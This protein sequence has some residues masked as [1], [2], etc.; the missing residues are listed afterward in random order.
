MKTTRLTLVVSLCLAACGGTDTPD[1]GALGDAAFDATTTTTDGAAR[2][3][4]PDGAATD[5][6]ARDGGEATSDGALEASTDDTGVAND[7]GSSTPFCQ[8]MT[9]GVTCTLVGSEAPAICLGG[10]CVVSRC[11]DGI[12][13]GRDDAGMPL[14]DCDD[15]NDTAGDGCENT[16]RFSCT[17]ARDCSDGNT[18]TVDT[19]EDH[20][21]V[22]TTAAAGTRCGDMNLGTCM[23]QTC[24]A[25]GCGNGAVDAG[26]ECD[27]GNSTMGDGCERDCRFTCTTDA[28][29]SDGNACNGTETCTVATH[30]CATGTAVVCADDGNAC[31]VESC[32]PSTG[33]C[34]VDTAMFDR[35]GD[36]VPGSYPAQSC[37]GTDCDDMNPAIAPGLQEVCGNTV[38]DDCNPATSDNTQT[39]YYADC[40]GD[41]FAATSSAQMLAC[42]APAG[43]PSGCGA[44][45][46]W[47]SRV[48]TDN[49][50][51]DCHD[52]NASVRPGQ[53]AF[54]A[55]SYAAPTG[56]SSFDYNCDGAS[57]P[58]YSI[59]TGFC[60]ACINLGR[61]CTGST[62]LTGTTQPACGSTAELSSCNGACTRE[63]SSI[64]LACR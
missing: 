61:A 31:T 42:Q 51:T 56:G 2:D 5:G 27:D 41:G 43:A 62:Y 3:A 19:C 33:S 17:I 59:C 6:A 38:D 47:I 32:N 22:R 60:F 35:D 20:T 21:C 7:G 4:T 58:Q 23:G 45:G 57:S 39:T 46:R 8:G 1:G 18:C 30:R 63:T 24:V 50:N 49:T 48:P 37:N 25:P 14:E 28:Q 16:C 40:D 54:F 52:R 11:G 10:R 13:D 36:G 29:C 64:R 9:D 26:E 53:T 44:G 12:V 55:G 15:G 34:M